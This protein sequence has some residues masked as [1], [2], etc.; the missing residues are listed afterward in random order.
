MHADK[1]VDLSPPMP[2]NSD[3]LTR[4]LGLDGLLDAMAGGNE[5]IHGVSQ[6]ALL[7]PLQQPLAIVYR[8]QILADALAAPVVVQELYDLA[9]ETL[10]S[11][12]TAWY[13]IFSTTP[14][15][16]LRS[17][18]RSLDLLTT[19]LHTLRHIVETH[20]EAFTS[21]G[22]RRFAS[23]VKNELTEDYFQL[24]HDHLEALAFPKGPLISAQLG[25]ANQGSNFVLRKPCPPDHNPFRRMLS[26]G[27]QSF[28]LDPRDD[29]GMEALAQMEARGINLVANA[30][31][32]SA[33]HVLAFFTELRTELAFY[34]GCI[35]LRQAL[36][37]A[38]VPF[39][40]PLVTEAAPGLWF[41]ATGLCDTSL[42]LSA[43]QVGVVG[44]DVSDAAATFIVVTG[45]NEGGKSTFL[46]S[47]GAA[48][49]MM[50]AGM[51]VCAANYSS[52][53][54]PNLQTHFKRE[55]DASLSR[56]KLEEELERMR[57]IAGRI[58]AGSVVLFNESFSS[59]NERE[60][61]MIALDIAR[62][63]S[64]AGIRMVFVTHSNEFASALQQ[65]QT[66]RG[67]FLRAERTQDGRRTFKLE[68]AAPLATSFSADLY[69]EVF[70]ADGASSG[71]A[72]TLA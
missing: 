69:N 23:M 57:S 26:G 6:V 49:L 39:C 41:T 9:E 22:M 66:P 47:L 19:R 27:S 55:E 16:I 72:N 51:F 34:L 71:S 61:A 45:A 5:V 11:A 67:L 28:Q 37:A 18:V 54:C 48:Q 50:H 68:K 35:N 21:P 12:K 65:W 13:G 40:F 15:S 17:S 29:R 60:G 62:A 33:D 43:K 3:E 36:A 42:A 20:D 4:D 8:Q 10:E 53:V 38:S 14:S 24:I 58:S 56:G 25:P 1:D 70:G 31:A 52:A 46:R 63:F 32:Q 30:L 64:E 7:D 2:G 44:N 59:T